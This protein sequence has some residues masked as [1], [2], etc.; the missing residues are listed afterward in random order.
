MRGFAL[1]MACLFAVMV[2]F[3][4]RTAAAEANDSQAADDA[5]IVHVLLLSGDSFEHAQALT[6]GL[7]RAVR[8]LPG[9]VLGKGDFSLEV[10]LA[11]LG[12]QE[13]PSTSCLNKIGDKLKATQYVWGS[14]NRQDEN[15]VATLNLWE[16]N[17]AGR[18]IELEYPASMSD[19]ASTKLRRLATGALARL[20]GIEEGKITLL[21]GTANGN[22]LVDGEEGPSLVNGLAELSLAPGVHELRV[23]AAGY[24]DAMTTVDVVA[25]AHAEVLV[26]L[27]RA[28]LDEIPAAETSES[29]TTSRRNLRHVMGIS[30]VVV[31]GAFLAGGIYSALQVRAI[32]NDAGFERY[33]NGLPQNQD[34]CSQADAGTVVPNAPAP[35]NISDMCAKANAFE[36]L[37][38]VFF[39]LGAVAGGV[40]TY[41]LLSSESAE[42]RKTTSRPRVRAHPGI[43][44]SRGGARL[45]MDIVF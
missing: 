22:V 44:F 43:G 33:R 2:Q 13:P 31:G 26:P 20:H 35:G 1:V 36:A 9:F 21:A 37:Q 15:V 40:G 18:K 29:S 7:R 41:L 10:L 17:G 39:G 16:R 34:A 24:Q 45:H 4:T 25:G 3:A 8:H 42:E 6:E 5:R 28:E 19:P 32:G 11:A 12:C 14:V 30:G 23:R 38:F 27:K